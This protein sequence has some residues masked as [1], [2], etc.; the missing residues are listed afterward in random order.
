MLDCKACIRRC[1]RIIFADLSHPA[2]QVRLPRPALADIRSLRRLPAAQRSYHLASSGQRNL[3]KQDGLRSR[4]HPAARHQTTQAIS[5]SDQIHEAPPPLTVSFQDQ[6][7]N[8]SGVRSFDK[9]GPED[10][11]TEFKK[12]K[13][14]S[15]ELIYLQDPLKL[16]ENTIALLREDDNHK[17]LDLVRLASKQTPC[18]VS[19]NHLVDYEMSKGRTQ[20]AVKIYN[21]MKKRAQ[22]PDAQTYTILLRGLSWHPH[23]QESLPLALKIY[24]SM[25]AENCPVKPNIIH[26]NAVLKVCALARDMDAL[27]G[28]AAKLPPKGPGA[29]NNRTFTTILNAIRNIAW[30]NDKD[31]GD[32]EW[33]EKSL[34]R[35]RAVM[36]GRKIWEEIIPRWRAGDMM[37]DEELVCAMGRLLLLG[38]TEQDYD[39]VLSLAEQV[40]A[41]PRQKRRLGEPQEIAD[42]TSAMAAGHA[43]IKE[44]SQNESDQLENDEG[45]LESQGEDTASPPP[46]SV[47][48]MDAALANVFRP[49]ASVPRL[50]VA[51]PGRNTLSLLL[52]ACINLRAV[53][54]AQAYW[55]LLT[56]PSG[57]YNVDPDSEN[58]HTY[59]R[60]LRLQRASKAASGLIADM[61]SG[62]LKAMQMLQPK[63]F[64]IAFSACVRDNKNPHVMEHATQILTTMCK[65]LPEPDLKALEIF[66]QLAASQVQR[67][68]HVTLNALRAMKTVMRLVRN[69][70][71]YGAEF[72]VE[73]ATKASATDLFKR[74]IGLYDSVL[75]AAGDR[76]ELEDKKYIDK[77]K[78]TLA[79]WVGKRAKA[80]QE[81][82]RRKELRPRGEG[83]DVSR[84]VRSDIGVGR[85]E[86]ML[87]ERTKK[88]LGIGARK[89]VERAR[90]VRERSGEFDD[91][92]TE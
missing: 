30:H 24:H 79:F 41:L 66:V 8:P 23:L 70:I 28:V 56:D 16:A 3:L 55:G 59:L 49:K 29:P 87:S 86:R 40:M 72:I 6:R 2:Y 53:P 91:F 82:T 36:Q 38:S 26:T 90:E 64:R 34:R 50:S 62:E 13:H 89:R 73:N 80:I 48:T 85:H 31:L 10:N 77:Q 32:E 57:P 17:A 11:A 58:F 25:F 74:M 51:R 42:T 65:T 68:F 46:S 20:K 60:V 37:I 33:E 88:G 84:R 22:K 81:E 9:S 19:W 75:Y 39:D 47:P 63:T 71:N 67:D 54:S 92:V 61:Y 35:Q 15:R 14:L 69:Y 45:L 12:K 21:E 4:G 83:E 27:W 1:I 76:L 18:T 5:T 44:T 43:G 52:D 7:F 78:A